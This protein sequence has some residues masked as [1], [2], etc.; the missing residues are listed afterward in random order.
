MDTYHPLKTVDLSG[1]QEIL[2][3]EGN[4]LVTLDS[5]AMLVLTDFSKTRPFT[6]HLDTSVDQ[7]MNAMRTAHVRS[8]VVTDSADK[9]RGIITTADLMSRKVLSLAT[10]SGQARNDISIGELM[11]PKDK[12]AG[13]PIEAINAGNIGELLQTLKNEGRPHMLVVEPQHNRIRGI[14]SANEI[15][16]RLQIPVEIN[17]RATSFKELV[18]VISAGREVN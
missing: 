6:M 18:D 17:Q 15:A 5:P 9:F 3:S 14:I 11:T 10:S 2:E 7:A 13:V 8:I 12:L 1:Y 16:R 4:T